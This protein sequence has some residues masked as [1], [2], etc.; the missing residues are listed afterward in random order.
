MAWMM[1]QLASIGV[2]FED[3]IIDKIFRDSVFYYFDHARDSRSASRPS[4]H[5]PRRE[6]AIPSIYDEHEPVRPWALGEIV[7]PDTGLY[8]VA[9]KTTRTPGMYHRIDPDT[10]L[11]S[12]YFLENTEESI[13]R[14][15]RLRLA[16]DGL[17]YDDA[18]LYKCRALL[19]K[20]PWEVRRLRVVSR[21]HVEDFYGEA[22]EIVEGHRW[23]WVYVG[24][25]EDAPPVTIMMEEP[26]GPYEKKLLGLNKG[27]LE[28]LLAIHLNFPFVFSVFGR[29]AKSMSR[30]LD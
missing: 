28:F 15:V 27:N 2:A 6:W 26:L 3:G 14:S 16:L 17:G 22:Y 29:F 4:K 5:K 9:G 7:Q 12:P 1:D 23:G 20:G 19:K 25:E 8:R 10:G 24:P 21:D 11:D 13:H 30:L 18:G